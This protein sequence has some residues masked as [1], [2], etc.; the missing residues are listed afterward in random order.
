MWGKQL[1]FIR[2][3]LFDSLKDASPGIIPNW[4]KMNCQ[5]MI[6]HLASFFDVSSG[7]LH[8]DLVTPEE[9]LPK[10]KA[11]L[12]S[13]KAFRENTKAPLTVIGEDPLPL[14]KANLE[15]A[16]NS[17]QKSVDGFCTYYEQQG[18]TP[19]VHPVFGPLNFDEWVQL[20]FKHVTHHLRQFGLKRYM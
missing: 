5:Q 8:F 3:T 9:D 10:F 12:L 20:H 6:E 19:T 13:D 14:T 7:K 15:E 11:F 2:T 18:A 16:I 1:D 17:L 4:G